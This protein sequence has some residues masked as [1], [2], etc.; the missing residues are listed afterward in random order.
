MLQARLLVLALFASVPALGS[1]APAVVQVDLASYSIRPS[2]IHLRAGQP[3][4][5]VFTNR[6]GGGHDFT[7]RSFFAAAQAV[8]GPI[9]GGAVELGG[10]QSATVDLVP[11]RGTWKAHCGHFGHKM[12]G[13]TARIVAD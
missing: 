1:P 6:S 5:L 7:A 4:R 2:V 11:A 9:E 12:L 10:H 8:R 3:V 13:M